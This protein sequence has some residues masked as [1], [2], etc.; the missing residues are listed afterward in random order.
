M[1]EGSGIPNGSTV[2][3]PFQ[4]EFLCRGSKGE[5]LAQRALPGLKKCFFSST[6]FKISNL[7][8]SRQS[9][10]DHKMVEVLS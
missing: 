6:V 1:T 10:S 8:K 9:N 2:T 4:G 7:E 3:R 5:R